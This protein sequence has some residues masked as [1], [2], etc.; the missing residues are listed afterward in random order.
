[1][2]SDVL[3][4]FPGKLGD[5]LFQWP[6]AR[7]WAEENGTQI[8]VGLDKSAWALEPILR[9]QAV[10]ADVILLS[11]VTDYFCGGQPWHFGWK[12]DQRGYREVFHLGFRDFPHKGL[13]RN[14]YELVPLKASYEELAELPSLDPF[15]IKP[16]GPLTCILHGT[17]TRPRFLTAFLRA[18]GTKILTS[19]FDRLFWAG[20]SDE[21]P[22]PNAVTLPP[23]PLERVVEEMTRCA[24]VFGASSGIVALAGA[25]KAPCL[26]VGEPALRPDWIWKNTGPNQWNVDPDTDPLPVLEKL[27][28]EKAWTQSVPSL[29]N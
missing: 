12:Q 1:V 22:W 3:F 25:M 13:L 16:E 15:W 23:P 4:T 7:K 24:F 17:K 18:M 19:G 26:R 5:T 9:K 21:W 11:G 6:V 2:V 14:T 10:V 20:S 27:V 28:K 8:D 29:T